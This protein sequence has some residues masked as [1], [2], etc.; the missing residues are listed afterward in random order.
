[1][2][3]NGYWFIDL[4]ENVI[5]KIHFGF[6][7]EQISVCKLNL[8]QIQTTKLRKHSFY[9]I[10]FN[11]KNY[12]SKTR[13]LRWSRTVIVHIKSCTKKGSAA[14][15][16]THKNENTPQ[17]STTVP[18]LSAPDSLFY[19]SSFQRVFLTRRSWKVNSYRDWLIMI[20]VS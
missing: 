1:M 6:Y 10:Q 9:G 20:S 3:F 7:N 17:C 2:F 19:T 13:L 8:L 4:N 12:A 14:W 5:F 11:A 18:T 16:Q 15:E